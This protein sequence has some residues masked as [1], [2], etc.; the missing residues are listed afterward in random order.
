MR[1]SF[2]KAFLDNYLIQLAYF[3]YVKF[4]HSVTN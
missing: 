2:T 1:K 3:N 4:K